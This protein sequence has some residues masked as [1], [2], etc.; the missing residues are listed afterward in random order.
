MKNFEAT[1][2]A[3][4]SSFFAW[5]V[6]FEPKYPELSL[7]FATLNGVKLPIGLAVKVKRQGM[8]RGVPDIIFLCK[9]GDK[10][11]IV[12]EFKTTK[13]LISEEQK[14][15]LLKA[16]VQSFETYV[17]RSVKQAISDVEE[18]LKRSA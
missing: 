12:A 10:S 3:I 14:T 8:R 4:Q 16:K 2:L 13:G 5:V 1:E 6:L 7:C 9:R 11:G 15:F 18:Y 17:W